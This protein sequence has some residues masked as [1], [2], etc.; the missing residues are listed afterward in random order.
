VFISGNMV[1]GLILN[2]LTDDRILYKHVE[3]IGCSQ[4]ND[5]QI[6]L[7]PNNPSLVYTPV[8]DSVPA[9]VD[10]PRNEIDI[11]SEGT[12]PNTTPETSNSGEPL[13]YCNQIFDGQVQAQ[14]PTGGAPSNGSPK[15]LGTACIISSSIPSGVPVPNAG[16]IIKT[17][18]TGVDQIHDGQ[19]RYVLQPMKKG[20][21]S[22]VKILGLVW[23]GVCMI[24]GFSM[25]WT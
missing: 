24:V 17:P 3:C 20:D 2:E 11:A 12:T 13:S 5:G 7:Q 23:I 6:Q 9:T 14:V 18:N 22:R 25:V 19:L 8:P 21:A 16:E 15:N 4:I 10:K 1:G